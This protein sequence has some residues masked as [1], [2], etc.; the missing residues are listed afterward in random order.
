DIGE[1]AMINRISGHDD[2]TCMFCEERSD[3]P[4]EKAQSNVDDDHDEDAAEAND[5]LVPYDSQLFLEALGQG[6]KSDA[7]I[8]AHMKGAK[9]NAPALVK[10]ADAAER[11]GNDSGALSSKMKESKPDWSVDGRPITP[12][13]HH[14]IPGNEAL[15]QAKELLKWIFEYLGKIE[16]DV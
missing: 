13:A 5:P 8:L 4:G 2:D 16:A 9:K 15:K 6:K 1:G 11:I 7:A 14:L 10:D 3:K 12:N